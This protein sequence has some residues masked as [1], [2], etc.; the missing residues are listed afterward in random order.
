MQ[1][2]FGSI[3]FTSEA[4]SFFGLNQSE[5]HYTSV[6][7]DFLGEALR[8]ILGDRTR[9]LL[10]LD[11]WVLSGE[12]GCLF[13]YQL[14]IRIPVAEAPNPDCQHV[15]IIAGEVTLLSRRDTPDPASTP[16]EKIVEVGEHPTTLSVGTTPLGTIRK[17][18]KAT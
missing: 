9:Y 15:T 12:R 5:F 6:P 18:S 16:M 14:K 10:P 7:S 2:Y 3:R 17:A 13:D 4:V 1:K 8:T 11:A